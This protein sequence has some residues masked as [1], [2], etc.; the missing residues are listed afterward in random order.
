MTTSPDIQ[1]LDD[2]VPVFAEA[3]L[4]AARAGGHIALT[5]GSTPKAAYEIASREASAFAQAKLWFGDERCVPPDD[6]RSN[7]RMARQSL[8]D[9][10]AQAG[11]EIG[12]VARMQG[13]RGHEAGAEAYE[14]QMRDQGFEIGGGGTRF[15]L[16]VLGIGGDGHCASMFPGQPS[17]RERERLV[18]G[19][20]EAGLEP[21]V[22]RITMTFPAL[23]LADDV[24]VLATGDSK[25]DA[26]AAAFSPESSPSPQTPASLLREH[27]AR[28]TVLLDE[29]AAARL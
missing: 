2:P 26:V 8:L 21:F 15:A 25:A 13:E 5:G 27:V 18:L 11:V 16:V 12:L 28:L 14:A 10:V 22:P 29:A 1:V 6:E 7:Y 24:I 23:A 4:A 20:P 9:P 17:L 19:V 3:L